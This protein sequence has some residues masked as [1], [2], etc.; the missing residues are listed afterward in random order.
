MA[1]DV[2]PSEAVERALLGGIL[3]DVRSEGEFRKSST[4]C[5]LLAPLLSNEERHAVG[6]CY[7]ERG[8]EAAI[9][10]GHR[11]VSGAIRHARIEAWV[12]G[13]SSR[14]AC[15]LFCA[16]GG[17][18]SEISQRWLAEAGIDL[19]RV[20]GGY[21][22]LR[23]WCLHTL[24]TTAAELPL[25][26]IGGRTGSRKTV[27][28]SELLLSGESGDQRAID[29]EALAAHRGSAFGATASP[30][31]SQ[32]T[33]EN[34]LAF[35]VA[36]GARGRHVPIF[37]EDE[38]RRIGMRAL[39]EKF[40]E[41]MCHAPLVV[42]SAPLEA[43]AR[44]I[45]RLYVDPYLHS[46]LELEQVLLERLT[47]IS[48]S[49]GGERFHEAQSRMKRAFVSQNTEDHLEWITY[50][51]NEYYDPLYDKHLSKKRDRVV[52]QGSFSEVQEFCLSRTLDKSCHPN[53]PI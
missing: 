50:L 4:P 8:R 34:A 48:R 47:R 18:R 42:I 2:P 51:L 23:N 53:P 28:L 41:R 32:A 52:F 20:T 22:A 10:L 1:S 44:E 39:P 26:V 49:L 45:Q 24:E 30:Q 9:A 21:K 43:R 27:L 46:S 11:L 3:L 17:L 37:V 6:L 40:F 14:R 25:E 19:P 38:S 5:T 7:R 12:E 13:V 36:R 16:R 33:F 29:L 15:A 35:E 31:P